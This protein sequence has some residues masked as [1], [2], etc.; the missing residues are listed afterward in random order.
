MPVVACTTTAIT[1][2]IVQFSATEF[3][4][5]YPQFNLQTPA[6][7]QNFVLAQTQ[8]DNTCG[9]RVQDANLRLTLLYLLTAHITQLL[10]GVG[11]QPATGI[12]GRVSDATEG[13]VEVQADYETF[14]PSQDYY[15]QTPFG[16]TYWQATAAW[17]T[18]VYT[19]GG[20]EITQTG[21]NWYTNYL[22]ATGGG[23]DGSGGSGCC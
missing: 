12:V 8:L 17:R 13:S 20:C 6:L 10:N 4:G 1:T 2:G 19:P 18:M 11:S 22:P 14:G 5:L 3:L 15:M 7:A 9:S 21:P 23:W 16:V